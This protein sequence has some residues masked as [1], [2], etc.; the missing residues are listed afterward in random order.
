MLILSFIFIRC[1]PSYFLEYSCEMLWILKAEIVGYLIDG[2]C[3]DKQLF[4]GYINYFALYPF[5]SGL[6]C[7]FLNQVAEVVGR[8][9]EL[10]GTV[11]HGGQPLMQGVVACEVVVEQGLKAGQD[12]PIDVLSRDELAFVEA[13]AIVEQQFDVVR[14]Q[15][16]A[17]PV[18][19]VP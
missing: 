7:F 10:A 18:D 14:N 4:F 17:Q 6:P 2:I 16:L 19:R 9:A 8:Q 3:W 1:C 15:S 5:Q 11:S 13:E 12:V